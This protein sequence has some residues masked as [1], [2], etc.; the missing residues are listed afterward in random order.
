MTKVQVQ[1]PQDLLSARAHLIYMCVKN[2]SINND[3]QCIFRYKFLL[4]G[5]T[6]VRGR[7]E[8]V[9]AIGKTKLFIS[10]LVY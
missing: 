7:G 8:A 9:N 2:C 4:Q 5:H 6:G 1:W 10:I 3:V